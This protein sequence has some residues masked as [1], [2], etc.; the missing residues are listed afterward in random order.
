MS[1]LDHKGKEMCVLATY[2][3]DAYICKATGKECDIKIPYWWDC[4][5]Y[6]KRLR[7]TQH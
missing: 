2:L 4:I 7:D 3:D 5:D 1:E 6:Y